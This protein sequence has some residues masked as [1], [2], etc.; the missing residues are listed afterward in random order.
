LYPPDLVAYDFFLFPKLSLREKRFESTE[1]VKENSLKKLKAIPS[2][3]YE[4]CLEKWVK[5]WHI[6]VPKLGII[7]KEIK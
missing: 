1:A 5:H 2:S 3:A 7:S 4:K 6:C